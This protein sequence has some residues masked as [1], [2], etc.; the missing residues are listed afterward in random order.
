[1]PD[2]FDT[3]NWTSFAALSDNEPPNY[4]TNAEMC[5]RQ[6]HFECAVFSPKRNKEGHFR[7]VS[8]VAF[9]MEAAGRLG[10]RR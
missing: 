6:F 5:L 3:R 9:R 4:Q 10:C 8:Q 2:D 7:N 1:M